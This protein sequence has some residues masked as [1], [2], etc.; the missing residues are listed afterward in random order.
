MVTRKIEPRLP[1]A[2]KMKK[3]EKILACILFSR[4]VIVKNILLFKHHV[5]LAFQLLLCPLFLLLGW[6]GGDTRFLIVRTQ[7]RIVEHIGQAMHGIK[8]PQRRD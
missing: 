8:F 2:A 6:F 4:N 1:K 3:K 7:P 5:L